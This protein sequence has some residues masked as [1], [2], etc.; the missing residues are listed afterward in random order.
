MKSTMITTEHL[1]VT[2]SCDEC[3]SAWNDLRRKGWKV[4]KPMYWEGRG[5]GFHAAIE[6]VKA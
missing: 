4:S 5:R 6:F 2:G 1:K 3:F